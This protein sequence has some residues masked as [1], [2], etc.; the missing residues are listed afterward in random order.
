MRPN[1]SIESDRAASCRA[2]CLLAAA[3]LLIAAPPALAGWVKIYEDEGS[4]GYID[5]ATIKWVDGNLRRVSELLDFKRPDS[6]F[7]GELSHRF[8]VEYDCKKKLVRV[9]SVT[10]YS[11]RMAQGR[12][13][14]TAEPKPNWAQIDPRSRHAN[15]LRIVCIS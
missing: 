5:P 6:Q 12:I 15:Q 2:V 14:N 9:V 1:P 8:L 13:T 10:G 7:K 11:E 3:I 4:V